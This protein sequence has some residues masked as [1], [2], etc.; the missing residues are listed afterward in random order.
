MGRWL[1]RVENPANAP[2]SMPTKPTQP[3]YVSSVGTP[4][5]GVPQNRGGSVSS[6]GL[7]PEPFPEI[8]LGE[9]PDTH[10][11]WLEWIADQVPL[12]KGDR[13]YV[14]ARLATLPPGGI[15]A[16]ARRYVQRWAEAA[17][18]EPKSHRKENAGRRAA[19]RGLLSL[20]GPGCWRWQRDHRKP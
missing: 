9:A 5:G 7:Q 18:A 16:V 10:G 12:V 11:D 20:V 15:E 17:D 3:G 1:D 6:V 2:D 19:N 8:E 4:T 13:E 14:W